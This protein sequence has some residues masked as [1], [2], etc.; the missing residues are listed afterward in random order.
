[1]KWSTAVQETKNHLGHKDKTQKR[2]QL[3]M[4]H[5]ASTTILETP[6][7]VQRLIAKILS[8]YLQ[9]M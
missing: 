4:Y 7:I 8:T 2:K 9:S 1:M 3:K 6:G 5:N